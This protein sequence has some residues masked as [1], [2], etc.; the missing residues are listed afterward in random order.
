M[1]M[2]LL[3]A[4]FWRTMVVMVKKTRFLRQICLAK[5][6][7]WE[8]AK[9]VLRPTNCHRSQTNQQTMAPRHLAAK[10]TLKATGDTMT[11]ATDGSTTARGST[12][13]GGTTMAM[14]GMT[15][16]TKVTATRLRQCAAGRHVTQRWR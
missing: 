11:T 10:A 5:Y 3:T 8:Y 13:T 1:V 15:T 4:F 16:Q 6:P 2:G 14:G 9:K 7:T 12:A